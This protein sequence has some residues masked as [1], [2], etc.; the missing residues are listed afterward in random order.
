M[1]QATINT[2][3]T[4]TLPKN[5]ICFSHL[6]WNFV[7][8]RPQHL[9]TRLGKNFNIHFIEEPLFDAQIPHYT[10]S[11]KGNNVTEVVPHLPAGTNRED[12]ISMQKQLLDQFMTTQKMEDTG[13]WYYTPMALQFTRHLHPCHDNF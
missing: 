8:Q 4:D 7:Y 10:Y 11:D 13:F 9:L 1:K 12:S 5:L 2:I 6:R 3:P